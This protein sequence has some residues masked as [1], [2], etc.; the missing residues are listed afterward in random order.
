MDLLKR[1][2]ALIGGKQDKPWPTVG[3]W[4]DGKAVIY[5]GVI[6]DYPDFILTPYFEITG[7]H[8]IRFWVGISSGHDPDAC[9]RYDYKFRRLDYHTQGSAARTIETT[10]TTKY[11]RL[12]LYKPKINEVFVLDVTDNKYILLGR[13]IKL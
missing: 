5:S 4:L 1:R 13:K 12:S 2:R 10:L 11:I 9:L 3:E 7:G 6:N 8:K